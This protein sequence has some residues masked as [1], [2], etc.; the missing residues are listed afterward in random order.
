MFTVYVLKS[1]N[2]GRYYVG[3]SADLE[4]RLQ[5][6]NAGKVRSTKAY[7]PWFIVYKEKFLNK[8]LARKRELEIKSFKS[9]NAFKKLIKK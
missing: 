3:F 5:E 1:E 6:H 9:G 2:K 4:K 7:K 8:I